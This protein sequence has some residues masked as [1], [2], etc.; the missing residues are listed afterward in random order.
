MAWDWPSAPRPLVITAAGVAV[1]GTAVLFVS[2]MRR[3]GLL[4]LPSFRRDGWATGDAG[5]IAL[6]GRA[7][8]SA[9]TEVGYPDA[10]LLLIHETERRLTCTVDCPSGDGEALVASGTELSERLGCAVEGALVGAKRVE[11]VLTGSGERSE[12]HTSAI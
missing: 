5:R 12:A 6:V 8:A 2:R 4:Q 1:L 9:I 11:L 10:R 3:Q 7:V